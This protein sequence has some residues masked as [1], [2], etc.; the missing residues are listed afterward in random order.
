MKGNLRARIQ[1]WAWKQFLRIGHDL[2]W[3]ADE[4]FQKQ[5]IQLRGAHIEC[6]GDKNESANGEHQPNTDLARTEFSRLGRR[7]REGS[8][9]YSPR[10]PLRIGRSRT[11]APASERDFR[12]VEG[13]GGNDA[14]CARAPRRRRART[15]AADFDRRITA[16][17]G[18]FAGM[19][20]AKAQP[21]EL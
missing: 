10:E 5:E 21:S 16:K 4:W 12:A 13:A 9:V 15:G 3:K 7:E 18:A 2:V 1:L 11:N 17:R 6:A 20:L 14:A 19:V 8:E